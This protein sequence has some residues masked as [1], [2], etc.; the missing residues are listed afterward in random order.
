MIFAALSQSV[1][2]LSLKDCMQLKLVPILFKKRA[3]FKMAGEC[4]GPL[5]WSPSLEQPFQRQQDCAVVPNHCYPYCN[6]SIDYTEAMSC[7]NIW[8]EFINEP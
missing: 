5:T 7:F 3:L 8:S 4:E 6:C 2:V 1:A